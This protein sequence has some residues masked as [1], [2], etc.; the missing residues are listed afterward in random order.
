MIRRAIIAAALCF[1]CKDSVIAVGT[2]KGTYALSSV[3]D[4]PL[5]YNLTGTSGAVTIIV[6][7]SITLM[8][9]NVFHQAGTKKA[10]ANGA[11]T[12]TE[13]HGSY[14]LLST[15]ITLHSDVDNVNRSGQ[16]EGGTMT[17]LDVGHVWAYKKLN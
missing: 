5:P 8:E 15:S 2:I 12:P 4:A 1:G 13:N 11:T 7:D 3:D 17:V 6:A 14:S 10:T 9:G 16:I